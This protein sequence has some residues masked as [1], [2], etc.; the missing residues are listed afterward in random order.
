MLRDLSTPIGTVMTAALTLTV[1][2]PVVTT[3]PSLL[4]KT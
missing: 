4:L 2:R 3:T 1:F